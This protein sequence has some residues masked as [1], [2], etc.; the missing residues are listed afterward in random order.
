MNTK[1]R[2]LMLSAAVAGITL[3][4]LGGLAVH[5]ASSADTSGTSL[6]DKIAAKFNLKTADVQA[7][8][9]A[10]KAT[11]E[12]DRAAEEK[13]RLDTAVTD[14]KI[15]QAQEDLIIAKQAEMKTAMDAAKNTTQTQAERQAARKTQMDALKQWATDNNIP[16]EYL[17][18]MGGPSG[19]GHGGPGGPGD[20][21]MPPADAPS[22]TAT[23]AS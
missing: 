16:M 13:T 4:A 1:T 21:G 15:T 19:R 10:D 3:S 14:K 2:T 7:V 18:P 17:R 23:P 8:F 12:D 22:A 5:A 20:G 6:V 11:H 9:D